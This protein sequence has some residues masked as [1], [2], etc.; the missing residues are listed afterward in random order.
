VVAL[1]TGI[2]GGVYTST[3][4]GAT[5]TRNSSPSVYWNSVAS[6]ADGT[7][8]VATTRGVQIQYPDGYIYTS[9]NSGSSWQLAGAPSNQW[10]S[11]VSSADGSKLAA[12]TTYYTTNSPSP[13]YGL[14]FIS[15]NSGAT[16]TSNNLP[17]GFWRS[18]DLSADGS[19]LAG[20]SATGTLISTNSG[21]TWISNT[22]P[23]V[24]NWE[25]IFL[26]A[27]GTKL[28]AVGN[29]SPFNAAI[30]TS[31]NLW[32]TWVSNSAPF[33]FGSSIASSAASADGTKL[34]A[35]DDTAL[36][37]STNSGTT[38]TANDLPKEID[39]NAYVASAADGN[40]FFAAVSSGSRIYTIYIMQTTPSPQLNLRPSGNS[41]AFSWLVPSTNFV[42]QW[43]SDL[44]TTNWMTLT[45]VPVLNF[46]NLQ[47]QAFLSPTDSGCFFRLISQ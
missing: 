42:L 7:K 9:T 44:S 16:W 19:I 29:P 40:K 35:T 17:Q 18:V 24:I 10:V 25:S 27:D 43:N 46:T 14:L 28:T 1:A 47:N 31:T 23:A 13:V 36:Y 2:K 6:S 26:S 12:V 8:L 4:S 32:V 41:L 3:N 39:V 22:T 37:T 45:N 20:A 38:W 11:I 33:V 21:A 5:W 34:V 15:T 30:Y